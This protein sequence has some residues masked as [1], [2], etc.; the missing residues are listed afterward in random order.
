MPL[1]IVMLWLAMLFTALPIA[2]QGIAGRNIGKHVW[3]EQAMLHIV[4]GFGFWWALG[5]VVRQ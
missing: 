4:Y 1:Y 5:L 2:S 3:A